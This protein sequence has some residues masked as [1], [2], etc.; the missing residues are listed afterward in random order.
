MSSASTY[1]QL[2]KSYEAAGKMEDWM[3]ILHSPKLN[4]VVGSSSSSSLVATC[5]APGTAASFW[6]SLPGAAAAGQDSMTGWRPPA[7]LMFLHDGLLPMDLLWRVWRT[8]P[9]ASNDEFTY[10]G[11]QHHVQALVLWRH[12]TYRVT[13]I[14]RIRSIL[15]YKSSPKWFS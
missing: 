10:F 6:S 5:R 8:V 3:R 15:E 14:L 4:P 12:S 13:F 11:F 1:M 9:G 7:Q 2:L